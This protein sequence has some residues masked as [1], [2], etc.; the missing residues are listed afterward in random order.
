MVMFFYFF[1]L[2][3]CLFSLLILSVPLTFLLPLLIFLC[4]IFFCIF[5]LFLLLYL[6]KHPCTIK[7]LS[8]PVPLPRNFIFLSSSYI[9]LFLLFSCCS[10]AVYYFLVYALSF[11]LS[12]SPLLVFFIYLVLTTF[13]SLSSL[14]YFFGH[15][16]YS[17]SP[18]IPASLS[19][20][21][22]GRSTNKP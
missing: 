6:F 3:L 10:L 22:T 1:L 8:P 14:H 21:L 5:C 15:G 17:S 2:F 4:Y 20:P 19:L 18:L 7:L 13:P 16:L 9:L 12:H 11:T